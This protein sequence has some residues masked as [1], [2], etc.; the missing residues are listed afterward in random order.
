MAKYYSLFY[1]GKY[2]LWKQ[3]MS[4][5]QKTLRLMFL[6]YPLTTKYY[7]CFKQLAKQ[8]LIPVK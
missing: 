8:N 7:A 3:G 2:N 6:I 5:L 4:D 1:V